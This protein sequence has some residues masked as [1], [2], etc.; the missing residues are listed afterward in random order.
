MAVVQIAAATDT[1]PSD[2][3]ALQRPSARSLLGF[4]CSS[5]RYASLQQSPSNT[6]DQHLYKPADAQ[7]TH[8]L[9]SACELISAS[10]YRTEPLFLHA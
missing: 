1:V 6:P 7:C 5:V 3:L 4:A 8:A 2:D 10:F 9:E